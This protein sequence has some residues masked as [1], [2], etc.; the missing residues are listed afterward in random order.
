[1]YCC[2]IG[3]PSKT[4]EKKLNSLRGKYQIPDDLNPRLVVL[5]EWCCTPN[6]GVGVHKAYLLGGLRLPFNTFAREILHRLGIGLNQLNPN[7]WRL[8]VSMQVLWKGL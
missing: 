2:A 3:I 1:M 5:G 4:N 8:I 7:A 6:L